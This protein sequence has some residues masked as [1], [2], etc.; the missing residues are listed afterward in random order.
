M[1]AFY[2]DVDG[3][4]VLLSSGPEVVDSSVA[5][6]VLKSL[7]WEEYPDCSTGELIPTLISLIGTSN[8]D[9]MVANI[10]FDWEYGHLRKT[11]LEHLVITLIE[12][13]VIANSDALNKAF[14]LSV[15]KGARRLF[16]L[17]YPRPEVDPARGGNAAIR[18]AVMNG[19]SDLVKILTKD[20]RVDPKLAISGQWGLPDVVH[21]RHIDVMI[22]MIDDGR[23]KFESDDI[24]QIGQLDG[25]I[26]L[27]RLLASERALSLHRDLKH[28]VFLAAAT[29]RLDIV[30]RLLQ[31]PLVDP[32]YKNSY[33]MRVACLHNNVEM[34]K[35]LLKDGRSN[36]NIC[37]D[38][39]RSAVYYAAHLGRTELCFALLEDSRVESTFVMYQAVQRN[40]TDLVL[41]LLHSNYNIAYPKDILNAACCGGN[42]II[43]SAVLNDPRMDPSDVLFKDAGCFKAKILR[44]L[45][46]DPRVLTPPHALCAVA[47]SCD[48][49]AM[50][51]LVSDPRFDP[52]WN[53]SEVLRT[54]DPPEKTMKALELLWDD[55]RADRSRLPY[56]KMT[57]SY[58][59]NLLKKILDEPLCDLSRDNFRLI[60]NHYH[61]PKPLK[62]ILCCTR[63]KTE[64]RIPDE[65]F[66]DL[67]LK[68]NDTY[69]LDV[70]LLEAV[71]ERSRELDGD[72]R[73]IE[74]LLLH[75]REGKRL[76]Y[77]EPLKNAVRDAFYKQIN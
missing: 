36:P 41:A 26:A 42:E 5:T 74:E 75:C 16:D 12:R 22:Y 20:P 3:L 13:N 44:L 21:S 37:V 76:D 77:G 15:K 70:F 4:L 48:V 9:K 35:A 50:K 61:W 40:H 72:C 56:E 32:A 1:A 63:M 10:F 52:S 31:D 51:V 8:M 60:D 18:D 47:K 30:T 17:T 19:D 55:G 24:C 27:D 45:F 28:M 58:A 69:G 73:V 23:M 66:M 39:G 65:K 67:M 29:S 46:A 43:V 25:G 62:S 53:D 38:F 11:N 6:S 68:V 34:A 33:A 14:G 64:Y 2:G 7:P 59:P 57:F 71:L 49:E 54:A